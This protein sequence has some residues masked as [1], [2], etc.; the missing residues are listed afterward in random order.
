[1]TNWGGVIVKEIVQ[2]QLGGGI[3]EILKHPMGGDKNQC[4][5]LK[6]SPTLP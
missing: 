4:Y 6:T 3:I 1:M 5:F 2:L